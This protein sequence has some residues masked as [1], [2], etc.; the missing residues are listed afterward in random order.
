MEQAASVETQPLGCG[1]PPPNI[2]DI[3]Q[4]AAADDNV[5][6]CQ[7][8]SHNLVPLECT[9]KQAAEYLADEI[10]RSNTAARTGHGAAEFLAAIGSCL[11]NTWTDME[12]DQQ[13]LQGSM[14][15]GLES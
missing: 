1:N 2:V 11:F 12:R 8:K 6:S 3:R 7:C 9:E 10:T 13:A 4:L 15:R 5:K 14:W